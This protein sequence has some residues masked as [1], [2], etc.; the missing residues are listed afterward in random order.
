MDVEQ[1]KRKQEMLMRRFVGC[2]QFNDKHDCIHG[3]GA[4]CD[5]NEDYCDYIPTV[6]K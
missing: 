2:P 4:Y 6:K 1:F 5:F 3:R